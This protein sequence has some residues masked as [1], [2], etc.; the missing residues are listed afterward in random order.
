MI[1]YY[2]K[3]GI[4]LSAEAW[5]SLLGDMSYRRIARTKVLSAADP[6]KSFDVS[7]VWLGLDHSFGDGLPVIFETVVFAEGSSADETCQRYH[8]VEAARAG[9]VETVTVVAA[10]LEDPIVMNEGTEEK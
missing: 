1:G 4:P 7:T 2:D 3:D 6:S 10:T 8:S 5:V 9:H